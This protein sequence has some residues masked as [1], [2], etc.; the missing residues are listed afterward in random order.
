MKEWRGNEGCLLYFDVGIMKDCLPIGFFVR[1]FL[2]VVLFWL[3]YE[4]VKYNHS[5]IHH[6]VI[7]VVVLDWVRCMFKVTMPFCST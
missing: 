5:P 2:Y 3:Y 1:A 6:A 7:V 4:V